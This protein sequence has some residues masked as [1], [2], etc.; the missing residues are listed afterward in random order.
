MTLCSKLRSEMKKEGEGL[1]CLN[2]ALR[3]QGVDIFIVYQTNGKA[4]LIDTL[5]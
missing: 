3:K 5:R 1:E 2:G 4:G